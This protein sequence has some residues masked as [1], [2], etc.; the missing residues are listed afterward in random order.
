M[1]KNDVTMPSTKKD[2]VV[3]TSNQNRK[4]KGLT[5]RKTLFYLILLIMLGGLYGSYY[6]YGKYKALSVDPNIEA[7][8][9]TNELTKTLS[10][11]MELPKDEIPTLATISDK[12]KLIGQPF[13]KNAENGDILFAYTTAMKA[14]LYRPS[15]NKIINVAP[16]SINQPNQNS[17]AM[18]NAVQNTIVPQINSSATTTNSKLKK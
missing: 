8:R 7:Q 5:I 3:D 15:N 12:D 16:I 9:V 10:K 11:L 2:A 6:F 18:T 13:F 17:S 1:L 14:I 4:K